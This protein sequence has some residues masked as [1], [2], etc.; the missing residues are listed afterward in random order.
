MA[1]K[2]RID[3]WLEARSK[4]LSA[5]DAAMAN[6]SLLSF[7]KVACQSDVTAARQHITYD[8]FQR[9]LADQQKERD[10]ISNIFNEIIQNLRRE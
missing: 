8:Y 10:E 3:A 6:Q 2:N 7:L 4:K 9:G 1:I 5:R